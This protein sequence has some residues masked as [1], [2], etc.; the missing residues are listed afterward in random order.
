M[1]PLPVSCF[2]RVTV[3]MPSAISP[4]TGSKGTL[5]F[6]GGRSSLEGSVLFIDGLLEPFPLGST[7]PDSFFLAA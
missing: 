7:S 3:F 5:G 4:T 1:K 6:L 2:I